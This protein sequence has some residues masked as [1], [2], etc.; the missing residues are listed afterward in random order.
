MLF[1]GKNRYDEICKVMDQYALDLAQMTNGHILLSHYYVLHAPD[2]A[3][4]YSKDK[5]GTVVNNCPYDILIFKDEYWPCANISGYYDDSKHI[6]LSFNHLNS[7]TLCHE[8]GHYLFGFWD[9]Y[10]YGKMYYYDTNGDGIVCDFDDCGHAGDKKDPHLDIKNSGY[11]DHGY[12]S[13]PTG[14]PSNFGLMENQ[15]GT[16]EMSN[17][18]SYSYLNGNTTVDKSNPD[19]YSMQY[20]MSGMSCEDNLMSNFEHAA[21]AK[22]YKINYT[23]TRGRS[24]TANYWFAALSAANDEMLDDNIYE[25][26]DYSHEFYSAEETTEQLAPISFEYSD[27]NLT[28]NLP[29][30]DDIRYYIKNIA[31]QS[32]TQISP[33][34]FSISNSEL[35]NNCFSLAVITEKDNSIVKNTYDIS[36][37][38]EED[39]ENIKI[40]NETDETII[41]VVDSI[42]KN[43]GDYTSVGKKYT[44]LSETDEFS[45]IMSQSLSEENVYNYDS[46]QWQKSTENGSVFLETTKSIE[47]YD[48]EH[49]S[50][51]IEGPGTYSLM[52][53]PTTGEISPIT[54]LR[55]DISNTVYDNQKCADPSGD[56]CRDKRDNA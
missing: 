19:L 11:W 54:N 20:Y 5:N 34:V 51:Y 21:S 43:E 25:G 24:Q 55:A 17:A 41:I 7:A 22:G 44:L 23:L 36:A 42:C 35:E 32:I 8:S 29:Q 47:E 48:I 10:C 28:I 49:I 26:I 37:I 30:N 15:Y 3:S 6:Y 38:I 14:A 53:L 39:T 33:T 9:E 45:G 13:R 27:S 56:Q 1:S 2:D 12:V 46:L 52:V 40:H 31:T 4:M 16:L 50:S 18:S